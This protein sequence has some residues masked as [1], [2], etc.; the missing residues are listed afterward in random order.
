MRDVRRMLGGDYTYYHALA[1]GMMIGLA[2]WIAAAASGRIPGLSGM[3]SRILQPLGKMELWRVVFLVG[4]IV[5]AATTFA[6]LEPAAHYRPVASLAV[7]AIA[8]VLVGFGTR[9]GGGC[10]SGHGVCGLGLGSRSA[11]AATLVFIL[12]AMITVFVVRQFGQ[13]GP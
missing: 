11:L 5:G 10:T 2:S 1:G 7:V 3:V 6:V 9:L 4:L 12:A 8:G 13:N